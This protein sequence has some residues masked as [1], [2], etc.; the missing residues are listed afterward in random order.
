MTLAS[1]APPRHEALSGPAPERRIPSRLTLV[2]SALHL[3]GAERAV[4]AL[5]KYWIEEGRDVG[6]V[7]IA[8]PDVDVYQLPAGA[9][10]VALGLLRPSRNPVEAC[11][12]ASR[13]VLAL[14]RA[15]VRLQPDVVVSFLEATNVLSLLATRGMR[16]PVIVCERTDPRF[17]RSGRPWA[18]LRRVLYPLAAAV[19]VQ[20][21]S[22]ATW[23]RSFCP[24]VAVIENFVERP[25]RQ[26]APAN[27]QGPWRLLA[28]GRLSPEKG[29]DLLIEA[30]GRVADAR[31]DWSLTILGEG[32]E[33][34]R[35]VG[36][37]AGLHLGE[38][39]SLPG[40]AA[41]PLP[42][43]AAAHAFALPSRYEGFPNALLEAMA[44]GLP[45]VAFDCPS[46]PSDIIAHG[47]NGIL[48]AAGDV[49]QLAAALERLMD[50][51]EERARIGSNAR[52]IAVTHTPE[53][54]LGRWDEVLEGVV[55]S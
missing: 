36:L 14:R 34:E 1:R 26:A 23:A 12:Q 38:R 20:T 4:C 49:A 16:A 41:D 48:V 6:V 39:V 42:H 11:F 8:S 25:S 22:V 5:A 47:R 10:R 40:R 43:L 53:R 28:M 29:F 54:L 33:R 51:P 31:P 50:S 52:E 35:L 30:F 17:A 32:P 15:L 24:R 9:R 19:V 3:G 55:A 21:E 44:V 7:T 45:A 18:A 2:I 27:G 37:A 46:G 13:R